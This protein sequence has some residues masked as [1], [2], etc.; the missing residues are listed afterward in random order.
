MLNTS[1]K[2]LARRMGMGELSSV[3][4]TQFYIDR[5]EKHNPAINAV[6]AERFEAALDEARQADE[7][8]RRGEPLGAL[9]GLPMTIKDAYEVTGLTCEVGHLPFKG[10]VSDR[11]A[12]VV[13]RLRAAGAIILGKT[14]T[15]LHCADLQT[16]NAIHGTTNNPHDVARTP[17]GSSGGAAA[18]L[19]SGMTPLELGSD[20]GGSIRTPSHFCGLFGHKPTFDIVPQRGHVPPAH[21]ALTTSA[22][23]VMGPLARSVEDLE[24]LLDVT[25]G[26]DTKPGSGLELALPA[27]RVE[28]VKHLRVGVWLGDDYCPVD[29]EIL[30]GIERAVQ[31]L[32][33]QGAEVSEAKPDFSLAEHHETYLMHLA[34]II[35]V[36]FGPDEI[37]L[38]QRVARE[39][40]PDDKS[41]NAIQARGTLLPHRDWLIWNEIRAHMLAKWGGFFEDYDVLICPVTPTTAMPHDQ[42]TP[43]GAR[44]IMVNGESRP[45]S[46]N[47][48][49]A[50]V[51]T[52]CS[53]PS[54]AVP[55]GRHSNGLPFGLQVIGPEYGD[56]TTLAVA[57]WLEE[58]GYIT[59]L[60]EGYQK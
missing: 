18:A 41:H 28:S 13:Q 43:F 3:E 23:G 44:K 59:R 2:D 50:G 6:I 46:D 42:D 5:I 20:I 16:Y 39:L 14:N 12:V 15:P 37:A 34:P 30:A 53:L 49:W 45:Y 54:T 47:V 17:G 4:V 51:A 57:R 48:V 56:R 11:D 33:L 36:N 32:A 21:G 1:A 58:A 60:A 52:L 27:S 29:H 35:G 26:F 31:A 25:A 24:L 22:L 38:M 8:V 9:H 10:R 40:G 55:V 7:K 19:A